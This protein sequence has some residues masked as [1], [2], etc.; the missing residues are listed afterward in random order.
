MIPHY[1]ILTSF[2]GFPSTVMGINKIDLE[3]TNPYFN[4]DDVEQKLIS[5]IE[6]QC[7]LNSEVVVVFP[8]RAVVKIRMCESNAGGI[9]IV[10]VPSAETILDELPEERKFIIDVLNYVAV[11]KQ[12][13]LISQYPEGKSKL[14][15][16]PD[17]NPMLFIED[18]DMISELANRIFEP[19]LVCTSNAMEDFYSVRT[20]YDII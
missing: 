6:K 16:L 15:L 20:V 11:S 3:D 5:D 12:S 7:K 4:P 13:G 17:G 19:T 9:P 18:N 14:F 1:T 8:R 2:Q 10:D